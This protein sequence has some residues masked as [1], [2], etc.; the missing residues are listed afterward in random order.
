MSQQL[1]L[2]RSQASDRSQLRTDMN[3][4]DARLYDLESALDRNDRKTNN[5]EWDLTDLRSELENHQWYDH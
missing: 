1:N 3:D 5:L 2:N 4:L